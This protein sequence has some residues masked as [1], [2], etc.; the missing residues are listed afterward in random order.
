MLK[1][2]NYRGVIKYLVYPILFIYLEIVYKLSVKSD[3][4]FNFIYPCIS[5]IT[6]GVIIYFLSSLTKKIVNRIIGYV[7]ARIEGEWFP[8][9][10]RNCEDCSG[11]YSR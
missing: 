9:R 4:A 7:L 11:S 10:P 1:E 6:L 3:F 2:K 8:H 5:A